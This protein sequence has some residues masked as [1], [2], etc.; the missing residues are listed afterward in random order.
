[1][2]VYP[3]SDE[4]STTPILTRRQLATIAT[5]ILLGTVAVVFILW[6]PGTRGLAGEQL[7]IARLD[8]L[9]VGLSI[10]IAGGGGLALYLAWRRQQS[11]EIGL[12][13]KDREQRHQERVAQAA[14]FDARERRITDLYTKASD[15]LGSDHAPV[16]LAGLYALERLA[17]DYEV[18]RQTVVFVLC[19]YLRM[20]Y[21][22]PV[23]LPDDADGERR[24]ASEERIQEREVRYTAH[25]SCTGIAS[26]TDL[27]TGGRSFPSTCPARSSPKLTSAMRTSPTPPSPE[28]T[29]QVL[30]LPT[31]PSTARYSTAPT[32]PQLTFAARAFMARTSQIQS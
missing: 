8:A 22:A 12:R 26:R 15:Q 17:Q 3:N 6:W 10:G 18:Q 24:R 25:A 5:G 14:E 23:P 4:T 27:M 16:R 20:P 28:P 19:A 11:T 7:V 31:P 13:Q 21:Q 29:S 2:T 1:V 30:S 9:K 32:S